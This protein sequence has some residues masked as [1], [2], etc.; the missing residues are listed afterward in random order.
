MRILEP[1]GMISVVPYK[2]KG[3]FIG[4]GRVD[5]NLPEQS[6]RRVARKCGLKL[7]SNISK[8]SNQGNLIHTIMESLILA[9]N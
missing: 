1:H 7:E 4:N 8:M 6:Q 3:Q 5:E 9:Q 2:G